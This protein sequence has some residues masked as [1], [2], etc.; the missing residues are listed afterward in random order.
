MK[1]ESINTAA[2]RGIEVKAIL[3]KAEFRQLKGELND[4]CVCDL[5]SG[6]ICIRD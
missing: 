2:K 1:I 3:G 5:D 6:R 4:L